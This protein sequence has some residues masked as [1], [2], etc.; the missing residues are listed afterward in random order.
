[1]VV[2]YIG[3]SGSGKSGAAENCICKLAQGKSKYYIATMRS[4]EEDEESI[5]RIERHRFLRR[6]K[7]FITIEKPTSVEEAVKEMDLK[8]KHVLLECVS[9]LTAN[10]MFFGN[11]IREKKETVE[12]VLNAVKALKD[13]TDNLVIVTNNVFEDGNSYDSYTISYLDALGEINREISKMA[14]EIYE[15][16]AGIEIKIK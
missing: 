8:E 14:D 7:G 11:E 5:K 3:G 12:R 10:E 2:L 4:N 1:M 9:N 13:N 16:V 6:D 15:C